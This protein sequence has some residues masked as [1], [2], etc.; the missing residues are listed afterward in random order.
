MIASLLRVRAGPIAFRRPPVA[1]LHRLVAYLAALWVC[2]ASA[3]ALASPADVRRALDAVSAS[4]A[5][6]QAGRYADARSALQ[7]VQAIVTA[8][9]AGV[10]ALQGQAKGA[11][12]RCV[13]AVG[14]L[15]RKIGEVA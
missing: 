5:S 8:E 15:D 7:Q 13:V 12:D 9:V 10:A 3:Q 1:G 14:E 6:T 4:I 2:M 11:F